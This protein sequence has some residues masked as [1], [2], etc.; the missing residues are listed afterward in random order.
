MILSAN[1]EDKTM[2]QTQLKKKSIVVSCFITSKVL[3][4]GLPSGNLTVCY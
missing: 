4:L 3:I 2:L 1:N